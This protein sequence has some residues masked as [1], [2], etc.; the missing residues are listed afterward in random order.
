M[1]EFKDKVA[2]ITGGASGVGRSL[3]FALGRRGAKIVVGDVDK[4]AMEQVSIDLAAEHIEAVV[5]HCD[6]TSPD[7]LRAVADKAADVLGGLD[8]VFA[9]AGIGAG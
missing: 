6:V 2:L 5:A 3:A 4:T 1:Q 7:S 8:L 9:N